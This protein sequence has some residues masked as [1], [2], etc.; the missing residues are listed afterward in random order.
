MHSSYFELHPAITYVYAC[1]RACVRV[2][3]LPYCMFKKSLGYTS[4]YNSTC[5]YTLVLCERVYV[6]AFVQDNTLCLVYH[7]YVF[8]LEAAYY[9]I[10]Q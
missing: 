6:C 7:V 5:I 8:V 9:Q 10:N 4:I 2:C 1:V 3:V